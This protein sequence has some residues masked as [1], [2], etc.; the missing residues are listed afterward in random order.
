MRRDTLHKTR[1]LKAPAEFGVI[2][3][4][5]EGALSSTL[6]VTDGGIKQPWLSSF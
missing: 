6:C 2:C 1:S 5:A 4:R 3:N